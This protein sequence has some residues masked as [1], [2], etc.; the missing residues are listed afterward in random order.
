YLAAYALT[1]L[2][3]F[4]IIALL[5]S[6][7][8][9]NDDLRDYAGLWHTHPALATL[10]TFFLRS[11]EHTSEL[12]SRE[13]LVCRLLP[14]KNNDPSTCPLPPA[15]GHPSISPCVTRRAP[16]PTPFPYTTLF[17]SLPGRL[18]ADQPRR[19]RHHRA[20]RLEGPS[21]RRP[22]RLCR[23]VAHAPRAR[24]AHDLLP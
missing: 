7:D 9:P 20:P 10:M 23:A 2:G 15:Q 6:K 22:A 16:P 21:Q 3:A 24:H 11:E 14:E 8:R 13:N 19:L 17:R 1:N 12:Q 5:G 4:G 18:R